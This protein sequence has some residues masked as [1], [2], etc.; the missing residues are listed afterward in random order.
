MSSRRIHPGWLPFAALLLLGFSS[1]LPAGETGDPRKAGWEESTPGRWKSLADRKAEAGDDFLRAEIALAPGTGV[2][3]EKRIK[4]DL[5][6]D[7]VLSIE[8][9]STGSN[10]TSRDYRRFEAAFPVSVTVVFGKDSMDIPW[11]KQ[12]ADFFREVRYGFSPGG[13]RL[14][15]SCGNDAPVK[16]MYRLEEEETVFVLCGEEERGKQIG[17]TR[18]IR[19]DFRA[20]Y[21]RDP[22]GP[23]TRILVSAIRPSKEDGRVDVEVRLSSPLLK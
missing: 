10:R 12:V 14:T 8:M 5:L 15:Y 13:I 17:G 23:V 1:Y 4:R 7:D 21:G 11:K 22:R 2:L 18:K 16:S 3:W 19:D 6:P 20:A 9:M